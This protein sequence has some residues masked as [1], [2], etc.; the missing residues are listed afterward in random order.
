MSFLPGRFCPSTLSF[1]FSLLVSFTVAYV[2]GS[3]CHGSCSFLLPVFQGRV[4]PLGL[5]SL[6]VSEMHWVAPL[7][8]LHRLA[9]LGPLS[10]PVPGAGS[11][12]AR[13][14]YPN[15][16]EFDRRDELFLLVPHSANGYTLTYRTKS[17]CLD[18]GDMDLYSNGGGLIKTHSCKTL[19]ILN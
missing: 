7:G 8:H 16:I 11:F 14:L 1:P 9:M 18:Q 19:T 3:C 15:L 2:L 13:Q 12:C 17:L 5:A 6:P 10:V 4:L